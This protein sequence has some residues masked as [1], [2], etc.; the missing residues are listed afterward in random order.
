MSAAR[1]RGL[2]RRGSGLSQ[3]NGARY[4]RVF[5]GAREFWR[6]AVAGVAIGTARESVFFQPFGD[7]P[8]DAPEWIPAGAMFGIGAGGIGQRMRLRGEI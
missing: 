6:G 2:V 1:L 5:A 4:V 3:W 8:I 7:G